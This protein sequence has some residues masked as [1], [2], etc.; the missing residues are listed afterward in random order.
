[1]AFYAHVLL[2]QGHMNTLVHSNC[3]HPAQTHRRVNA[4]YSHCTAEAFTSNMGM[5]AGRFRFH[6]MNNMQRLNMWCPWCTHTSVIRT[7]NRGEP[8]GNVPYNM[9]A[10]TEKSRW[11]VMHKE[12]HTQQRDPSFLSYFP[13]QFSFSL[14]ASVFWE[15]SV[16]NSLS[17]KFRL[18]CA[19]RAISS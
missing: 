12:R 18:H 7:Y 19:S 8:Q 2:H 17:A 4:R 5:S 16:K 6:V 9:R 11:K 10:E 14:P 1:M 13:L 15:G 3:R